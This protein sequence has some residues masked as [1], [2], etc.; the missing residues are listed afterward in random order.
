[1]S[2]ILIVEDMDSESVSASTYALHLLA[3]LLSE[4]A[5]GD[6]LWTEL[7][8]KDMQLFH[9]L[10]QALENDDN[11]TDMPYVLFLYIIISIVT[12]IFSFLYVFL[13]NIKI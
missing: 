1:M 8:R 6:V 2:I 12:F 11:G 10:L 13:L 4:R 7:Q 3:M 5:V 9:L